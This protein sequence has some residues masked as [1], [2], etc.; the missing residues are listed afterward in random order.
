VGVVW[1]VRRSVLEL[2]WAVRTTVSAAGKRQRAGVRRAWLL[3][4]MSPQ[5]G[6]GMSICIFIILLPV[7][8]YS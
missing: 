3:L 1:A 7:M 5:P 6:N 4:R 8:C 2:A